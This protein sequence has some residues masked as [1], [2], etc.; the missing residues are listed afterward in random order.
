MDPRQV[1]NRK[2]P[3][4]NPPNDQGSTETEAMDV[5]ATLM[6]TLLKRFQSFKPPTLKGTE[7]AVDCKIWL[8]DIEQLFDSLDYTDDRRIR[9]V[10]HQLQGIAKISYSKDKGAEFATLRKENLN[11]EEYVAKFDSLLRFAPHIANNEEAKADQVI[12]GLNPDI[13]TLVNSGRHDNFVDE[14]HQAKGAKADTGASHTFISEK[15]VMMHAF[16]S[17]PLLA[18]FFEQLKDLIAKGY[19]RPSVSLWGA[20]V[21]FVRKKYGSMRLCIDY[22]QLNQA[23]TLRAEQLFVKLSKCE[24][25]LD[26]VVFLGH[27]ISGYDIFV[28]P[29]KIVAAMNWPRTTSVPEIQIFMGL[30]G[31]YRRFIEE[32]SSIANPITQLTQNNA[33]FV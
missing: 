29:S 3:A 27:I 9:L 20:P 31:Y 18:I 23:T 13:F 32:F 33:L 30:A 10:V 14:L 2:R 7:N 1:L 5:T 15:F 17:D 6:K 11:I 22:R 24:F 12:N 19:I 26:R 16:T 25:W 21:L 4:V 28:D 8:E